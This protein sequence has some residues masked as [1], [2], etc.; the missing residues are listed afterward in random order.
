MFILYNMFHYSWS[1]MKIMRLSLLA[2]SW[3]V[4]V[5]LYGLLFSVFLLR[6]WVFLLLIWGGASGEVHWTF[7]SRPFWS[8]NEG[9]WCYLKAY[10]FLHL[11]SE[12]SFECLERVHPTSS[13]QNLI[14]PLRQTLI[15]KPWKTQT[16][17]FWS[18]T[19]TFTTS[20]SALNNNCDKLNVMWIML[21]VSFAL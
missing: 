18:W 21:L 8:C 11:L 19:E 4:N 2:C 3:G 6:F 20:W 5:L 14:T 13:N 10:S 7:S 16:L 1:G 9:F 12:E 17:T 15:K